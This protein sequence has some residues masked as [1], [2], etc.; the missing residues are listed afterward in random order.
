[1][2]RSSKV[3]IEHRDKYFEIGLNVAF[4]RKKAGMTQ[5]Q[6]AEKIDMNRSYLGEIEAPNMVTTLSLE[7]LFKIADALEIP[8]SKLLE[9]RD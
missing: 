2:G 7:M 4:Y 6:L 9:F 1:M 8:A 3:S 5:D